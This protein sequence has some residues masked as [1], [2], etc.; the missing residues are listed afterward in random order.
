MTSQHARGRQEGR[1]PDDDPEGVGA[2]LVRLLRLVAREV[3]A[4]LHSGR[5]AA[6]GEQP[7]NE[8]DQPRGNSG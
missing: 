8:T 7:G 5:D 4:R 3:A 6:R 1:G 2:L